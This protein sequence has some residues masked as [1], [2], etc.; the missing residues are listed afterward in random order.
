MPH[1]VIAGTGRAGTSF[2]VQ[3]LA[4]SG[5]DAGDFDP[6]DYIDAARAGFERHL[7]ADP[8]LPYVVKDPWLYTYCDR[9]DP[10]LID[11]LIV[12]M[13]DLEAAARSRVAVERAARPGVGADFGVTN[14]GMIFRNDVHAQAGVLAEGLYRLLHWATSHGVP[15]LLLDHA[16]FS[17]PDY[18][19]STLAD[20]LPDHYQA[21]TAHESLWLATSAPV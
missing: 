9:V 12:P 3:W 17:D 21:R 11:L 16:R 10:A 5:L 14:G 15:L 4:A 19:I 2:L 13:R 18:L 6:G 1:L 8:A 20:Q 7:S